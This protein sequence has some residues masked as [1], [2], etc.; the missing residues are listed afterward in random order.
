[1]PRVPIES[2]PDRR[3]QAM[4][5]SAF[6]YFLTYSGVKLPVRLVN[7]LSEAE[8]AN[9]NT[10]IRAQFGDGQ[11]L[12]Q[13]DKVVY[14]EVELTH[15]YHYHENGTLLSAEILMGDERRVVRFDEGPSGAAQES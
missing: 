15:R 14:G 2:A 9:R 8:L 3:N 7:P 11:R 5:M 13:F 12:M 1:M 10:Y 6:Q 4:V